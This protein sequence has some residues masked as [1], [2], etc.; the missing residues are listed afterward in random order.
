VKINLSPLLLNAS[1][2]VLG[3]KIIDEQ[4][5]ELIDGI[6]KLYEARLSLSNVEI[7]SIIETIIVNS[8]VHFDQ[9]EKE[10][11]SIG[12]PK[13]KEHLAEHTELLKDVGEFI[14][15]FDLGEDVAAEFQAFLFDWIAAHIR[16]SDRD[17]FDYKNSLLPKAL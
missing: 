5:E 1:D 6:N 14:A 17:I 7:R 4:H 11:K 13:I 3:D 12:Y 16:T 10:M 2:F 9:E 15:R 8:K